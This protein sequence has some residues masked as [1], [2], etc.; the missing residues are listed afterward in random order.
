MMWYLG[1]AKSE[2]KNIVRH[3]E[4][5]HHVCQI[6]RR[7]LR[8]LSCQLLHQK[9][10]SDRLGVFNVYDGF[11]ISCVTSDV[12]YCG[13]LHGKHGDLHGAE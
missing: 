2:R 13:I 8:I 7:K 4:L 1:Q 11:H 12:Q 6:Q 9:I 10:L 3:D 5:P